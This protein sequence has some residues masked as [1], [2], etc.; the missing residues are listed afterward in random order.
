MSKTFRILTVCL[1]NICRSPL[2]EAIV[3]DHL[4]RAGIQAMV[5]SAGTG[6]WH[7]GQAPDKRAIR[8]AKEN[9]I[10]IDHLRARQFIQH[11]FEGFDLIFAMDR[12]NYSDIIALARSA[13]ERSKVH[14]FLE[15]S[16]SESPLDVP[17][18]YYGTQKDFYAVYD[19]LDAA[20]AQAM[21]RLI[22]LAQGR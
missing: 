20:T 1:G 22:P 6:N 12:T 16:G 11:D 5:D 21:H 17:D 15:F 13:E 9:N 7:V 18:P 14:L 3:R 8:A 4:E 19:L 2:A 10:D